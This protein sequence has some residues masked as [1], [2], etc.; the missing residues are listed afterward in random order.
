[1]RFFFSAAAFNAWYKSRYGLA[2][3]SRGT[4]WIIFPGL[5]QLHAD[6]ELA[7]KWS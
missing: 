6:A 5:G 3:S 4:T 2:G 7:M 1:L